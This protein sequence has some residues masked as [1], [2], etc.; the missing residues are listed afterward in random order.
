VSLNIK[1]DSVH[2]AVRELAEALGVS[3]TSAVELAVRA[4]LDELR[5]ESPSDLEARVRSAALA[6][7][8]A[9]KDVDIRAIE[10]DLYD[11]ATGLPR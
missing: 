7:Q 10:S 9:F 11:E 2:A 6:A 8:E 3:Q 1:N 5:R 4:K